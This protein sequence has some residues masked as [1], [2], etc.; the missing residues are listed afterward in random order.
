[1]LAVRLITMDN[2]TKIFGAILAV[3]LIVALGA[4][5]FVYVLPQADD[6]TTVDDGTNDEPNTGDDPADD[7]N[8]T[9]E[10][11]LTINF[12]GSSYNY[13]LSDLQQLETYTGTGR[14]Q[15]MRAYP[16]SV[17]IQPGF[18]EEPFNYTGVTLNELFEDAF[19]GLSE[20][21]DYIITAVA[22]DGWTVNYTRAQIHGDVE[23]RTENGTEYTNST[24]SVFIVLAYEEN[25]VSIVDTEDGPFR[26]VF[27][28]DETPITRS[29]QW[30]KMVVQ[31]DVIPVSS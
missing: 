23:L 6:D 4:Y 31:L 7:T 14:Y 17:I 10:A 19:T 12:N 5:V 11:M 25:G 29:D 18:D 20:P 16:D 8:T 24:M 21:E 2:N 22:S 27:L 26:I 15:K 28:G 3:V 30:A 1:M 13:T 9:E